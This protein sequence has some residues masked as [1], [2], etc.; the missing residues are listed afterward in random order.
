MIQ[1]NSDP[2]THATVLRVTTASSVEKLKKI[3]KCSNR[4]GMH[5]KYASS[6]TPVR[7]ASASQVPPTN[8]VAWNST[9]TSTPR[10]L[11]INRLQRGTGLASSTEAALGSRK[12]GKKP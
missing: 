1:N 2:N 7:I 5:R 11:P 4:T 12:E 9:K 6:Q 3:A 8:T 10:Y